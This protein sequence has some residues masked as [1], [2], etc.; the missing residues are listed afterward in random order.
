MN[1]AKAAFEST[2]A[3]EARPPV[4]GAA[5][6]TVVARVHLNN[7]ADQLREA[8]SGL[9]ALWPGLF[10][11]S[12]RDGLDAAAAAVATHVT[13]LLTTAVTVAGYAALGT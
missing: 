1:D 12:S 6:R 7:L 11:N 5:L 8:H 2:V 3:K 10:N 9:R 4:N 13:S